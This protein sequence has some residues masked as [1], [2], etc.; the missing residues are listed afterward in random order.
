MSTAAQDTGKNVCEP[1]NYQIDSKLSNLLFSV[2]EL[3][4][5]V[6]MLSDNLEAV[7]RPEDAVGIGKNSEVDPSCILANKLHQVTMRIQNI[8]DKVQDINNRLEFN[9]VDV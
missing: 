4:E 7:M 8:K 6:V 1:R 9:M 5:G 3:E 2:T